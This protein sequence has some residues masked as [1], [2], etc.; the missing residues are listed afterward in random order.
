MKESIGKQL[1][2]LC[3]LKQLAIKTGQQKKPVDVVAAKIK[4]TD[5]PS[6]D[7][8]EI[9]MA[10]MLGF[11]SAIAG[12]LK[13]YTTV[14]LDK[15]G[16]DFSL[17]MRNYLKAAYIQMKFCKH[18]TKSYPPYITVVE[19]GAWPGFGG[20]TELSSCPGNAAL[21]KI[22]INSGLYDEDEIYCIFESYY[23]FEEN[24]REV[25]ELIKI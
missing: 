12:N 14:D 17:K 7:V 18:N 20:L 5:L 15:K 24:C 23:G 19:V 11:F 16:V 22:L 2:A 9:L 4:A 1:V 13:V 25:W 6:G 3:R 21:F 8:A 10:Y